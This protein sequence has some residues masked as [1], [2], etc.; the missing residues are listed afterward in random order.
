M[1]E[2][3]VEGLEFTYNDVKYPLKRLET[4]KLSYNLFTMDLNLEEIS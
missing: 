2:I 3:G 1:L 4:G